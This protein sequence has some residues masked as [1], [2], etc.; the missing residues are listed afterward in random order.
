[1]VASPTVEAKVHEQSEKQL[2]NDDVQANPVVANVRRP[3]D[4][5]HGHDC[6]EHE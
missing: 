1:M 3:D 6:R 4:A 5:P 2:G